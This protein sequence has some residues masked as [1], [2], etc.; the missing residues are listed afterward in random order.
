MLRQAYLLPLPA[1]DSEGYA[2]TLDLMSIPTQTYLQWI[3]VWARGVSVYVLGENCKVGLP[4]AIIGVG[5]KGG[6]A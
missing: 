2:R 1:E 6:G 4:Q 5:G 3:T